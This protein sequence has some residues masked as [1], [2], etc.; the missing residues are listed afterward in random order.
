MKSAALELL[1]LDVDGLALTPGN[2]P[3]R[4]FEEWVQ[5]SDVDAVTHHGY[6]AGALRTEVWDRH[7]RL[8]GAWD[9]VHPP[10]H[11]PLRSFVPPTGQ[12]VEVMY[13]GHYLGTGAELDKA[14]SSKTTLAVDIS[15]LYIQRTQGALSD[16]TWS[17]LQDYPHIDEIHLSANDGRRDQH[18]PLEPSTFGLKWART[19]AQSG[20]ILVL[21]SYFHRLSGE[22]RKRQVALARGLQ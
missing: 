19:R 15:H 3:T 17:R 1:E 13:P 5:T 9:S 18:R 7:H 4:G 22:E 12:C 2:A 16:G 20:P 10:K 8:L 21:E 6:C 11:D 14:M